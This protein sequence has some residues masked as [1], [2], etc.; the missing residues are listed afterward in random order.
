[1]VGLGKRDITGLLIVVGGLGQTFVLMIVVWGA[2]SRTTR[3][4]WSLSGSRELGTI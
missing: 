1:M 2:G 4:H 3:H